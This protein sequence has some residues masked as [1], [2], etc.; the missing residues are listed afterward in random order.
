MRQSGLLLDD[1]ND[2]SEDCL[3]RPL[4]RDW[5]AI[6]LREVHCMDDIL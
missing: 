6:L 3:T 2:V 4:V 5:A 1:N